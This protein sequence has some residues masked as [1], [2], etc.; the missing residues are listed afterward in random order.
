LPKGW[1][2]YVHPEGRPYFCNEQ[3]K[4]ITESD[5][6]NRE[7]EKILDKVSSSLRAELND[8]GVEL[9]LA[10][11]LDSPQNVN[12]CHYYF[13][14]HT[15]QRVFWPE[16]VDPLEYGVI[17]REQVNVSYG[18]FAE[19]SVPSFMLTVLVVFI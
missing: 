17:P 1:V 11:V 9:H 2:E 13:V 16:D 10:L 12:H 3:N 15:T 4:V 7:T 6:T 8:S 18:E 19:S 5:I 14:D